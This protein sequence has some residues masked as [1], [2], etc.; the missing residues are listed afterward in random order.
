MTPLHLV[1]R[2]LSAY[3]AVEVHVAPLPYGVLVEGLA[4]LYLRLGFVCNAIASTSPKV[5]R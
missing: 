1:N 3:P 4:E 5:I 2:W